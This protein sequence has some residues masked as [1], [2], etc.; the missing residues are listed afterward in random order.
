MLKSL[1]KIKKIVM[2][3]LSV[4][5]ILCFVGGATRFVS[6]ADGNLGATYTKIAH[7]EFKDSSN[8]GKDSLGNYDLVNA[9]GVVADVLNDGAIFGKEN[10][11]LYAPDLGEG[12]DFSD[13]IDGSFSVSMRLY[14]CDVWEGGNYIIATGSYGSNFC[15]EWTYGGIQTYLGNNQYAPISNVFSGAAF[16]WH[17]I[18]WIYD[19]STLSFRTIVVK[20]G[21]ETPIHD[22]TTTLTSEINFGGHTNTFTVGAQS[23]FGQWVDCL[24]D[25]LIGHDNLRGYPQISDLRIYTGAI[26]DVELANIADYDQDALENPC[27]N[28]GHSWVDADCDTP[29]TCSVCAATE[30]EALGHSFGEWT[31]TKEATATETGEKE[32]TCACGEKETETIPATGNVENSESTDLITCSSSIGLSGTS[33][34]IVLSFGAGLVLKKKR[35]N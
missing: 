15:A 35:E 12:K 7:Y 29:K 26:N 31:V 8:L 4:C 9:G 21:S 10:G 27:I 5:A 24:V 28:L 18:S 2:A 6:A 34:L 14:I 3:A 33:L 22:T 16:A 19:E 20:E 23:N 1:Q 17:R 25:G 32:R 30:G 11:F 13:L